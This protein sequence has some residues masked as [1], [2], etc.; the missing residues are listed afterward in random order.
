M[1][2]SSSENRLDQGFKH[3][4]S[5]RHCRGRALRE[6][7]GFCCYNALGPL[8]RRY[9]V[10]HGDGASVEG[11]ERKEREQDRRGFQSRVD[12]QRV[13]RLISVISISISFLRFCSHVLQSR[14]AGGRPRRPRRCEHLFVTGF[15]QSLICILSSC[16]YCRTISPEETSLHLQCSISLNVGCFLFLHIRIEWLRERAS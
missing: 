5:R 15:E 12:K 1:Y 10:V 13:N 6:R 14:S 16:R 4:G 8:T 7:R 2:E 9:D 11:E 3:G